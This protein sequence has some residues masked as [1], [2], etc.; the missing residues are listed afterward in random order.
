MVRNLLL[1]AIALIALAIPA[2]ADFYNISTVAL[3]PT[4]AVDIDG[5]NLQ[6]ENGSDLLL[7]SGAYFPLQ[8][9]FLFEGSQPAPL[10]GTSTY[11]PAETSIV[12]Q[13]QITI[14]DFSN[15]GVLLNTLEQTVV[16]QGTLFTDAAGVRTVVLNGDGVV[17][18]GDSNIDL[19]STGNAFV[20]FPNTDNTFDLDVT[21]LVTPIIP[22]PPRV[23]P[24]PSSILLLGTGLLTA[25]GAIRHRF[26]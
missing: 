22:P 5:D 24:E 15:A 2:R 18:F 3:V 19:I 8:T 14:T 26:A 7:D 1:P 16:F 12:I 9:L 4:A 11:V 6:A 17:Q 23:A 13:D 20:T 10:G 21:L 25:L